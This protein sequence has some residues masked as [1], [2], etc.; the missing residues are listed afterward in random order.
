MVSLD[1][2]GAKDVELCKSMRVCR[3]RWKRRRKEEG[4]V[5]KDVRGPI[6]HKWSKSATCL[7]KPCTWSLQSVLSS[8]ISLLY[9]FLARSLSLYSHSLP[10]L[11]RQAGWHASYW[12]DLCVCEWNCASCW[13]QAGGYRPADVGPTTGQ[14]GVICQWLKEP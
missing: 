10:C 9:L 1:W 11:C 4:I 7:V 6:M 13:S 14:S 12:W 2:K 5:E 8:C 3:G